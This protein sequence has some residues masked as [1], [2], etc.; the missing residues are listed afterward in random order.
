MVLFCVKAMEPGL[1]A[2]MTGKPRTHAMKFVAELERRR[3]PFIVRY[4]L[5]PGMTDTSQEAQELVSFVRQHSTCLGIELL[6]YHRL[7]V[8]KYE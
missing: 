3:V 8:D 4:V 1:Y 7:G 6:P 2:R 5:V